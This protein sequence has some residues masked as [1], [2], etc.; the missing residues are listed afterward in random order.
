MR[1]RI[2]SNRLIIGSRGSKLALIQAELVAAE[3]SQARPGL[4]IQIRKIVTEGDRNMAVNIEEAGGVGIFVKALEDALIKHEIDM[5]VH[6]LKD[7][8]VILPGELALVAVMERSDPRDVLVASAAFGDLKPGSKI[9]TSSVR[10]SAQIRNLRPDLLTVGIR[11]NVDTRLRKASS[12]EVDG[13][14]VAA[15][16][17]LRL[18]RA[19]E[20]TEYLPLDS[21]VPA[22]GQGALAIEA[23]RSDVFARD[24]AAAI[25]HMATWQAVTAER[26]FLD[27]LGGGC[28][29]PISCIAVV[30]DG[31]LRITGMVSDREGKNM[32][33]DHMVSDAADP[34][35]VGRILA[36]KM[37]KEGAKVIVDEI[38]C[39]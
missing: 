36:E 1:R 4:E 22:A 10:R 39:R 38:R 20:I 21:F 5:A 11:G 30:E 23:R 28:S 2:V 26:A 13:I 27:Y 35:A 17:M 32:L 18:D 16:A 3:L 15:A 24:L 29:A 12:G 7:L 34:E 33:K 19:D 14:I 6:S 8:P 9:G 37:L 25:N 31:S